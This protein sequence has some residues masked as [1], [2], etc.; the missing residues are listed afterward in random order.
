M[1]AL[2]HHDPGEPEFRLEE[3]DRRTIVGRILMVLILAVV[4]AFAWWTSGS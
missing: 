1:D 3:T 2:R 4:V